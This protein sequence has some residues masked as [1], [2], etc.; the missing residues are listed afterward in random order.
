MAYVLLSFMCL[1]DWLMEC[2]CIWTN[3]ILSVSVKV[4]LD[5]INFN[6]GELNK[7]DFAP[8]DVWA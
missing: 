4:Y 1:L 8:E 7:N 5:E 6:V 2:P 3:V